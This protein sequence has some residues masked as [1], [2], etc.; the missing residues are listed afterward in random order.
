[1]PSVPVDQSLIPPVN[2]SS[3]FYDGMQQLNADRSRMLTRLV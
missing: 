3:S 2:T 1:V